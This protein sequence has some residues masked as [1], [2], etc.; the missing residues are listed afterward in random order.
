[1]PRVEPPLTPRRREIAILMTEGRTLDEIARMLTITREA[2]AEDVEYLLRRLDR[3]NRAEVRSWAA[4]RDGDPAAED[5]PLGRAAGAARTLKSA[6]QQR[7][8]L[9]GELV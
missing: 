7:Q 5:A 9:A 1:M 8:N 6:T 2:V 3:A 4:E